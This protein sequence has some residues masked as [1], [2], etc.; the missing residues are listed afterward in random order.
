[1]SSFKDAAKLFNTSFEVDEYFSSVSASY[2]KSNLVMAI[3]AKDIPLM[4]LLGN[5]GTGKTYMLNLIKAE[6]IFKKLVLF[7]SEPF[8]SPESLMFF[9]LKNHK[10][11][12]DLSLN[13]LK[14]RAILAYENQ[15]NIIIIDEAQLLS[16]NVL[17]YIRILSDTGHFN[18]IISMHKD[19]GEEILSQQHFASRTHIAL[20][21]EELETN[22]MLKYVQSHLFKNAMGEFIELFTM[23][24][25]KQIQSYSKGNFRMLK[26]MVKHI[27]LILDY[28][29]NNKYKKYCE[30][31]K[32][33][34]TMA[35][36]DLGIV[37]V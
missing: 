34:I 14:D 2:V 32:C 16:H 12:R 1:M 19:E 28:A 31:N 25:M 26:Q 27:F 9:L 8:S 17:E 29:R 36:I 15:D 10:V 11:D 22:E 33:V 13:E 18:F 3:D 30:P 4:F 7:S 35:A 37:H 24:H 6:Y 23:K 5:P 21:L 20:S